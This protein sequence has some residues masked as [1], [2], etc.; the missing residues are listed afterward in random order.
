M[1]YSNHNNVEKAKPNREIGTESHGS[2]MKDRQVTM[3]LYNCVFIFLQ[4]LLFKRTDMNKRLYLPML[5]SVLLAGCGGG[6][7]STVETSVNS[8]PSIEDTTSAASLTAFE[9]PVL[10]ESTKQDYLDAI[11]SV[12]AIQQ[13]CGSEGIK[14]AVSPLVWNDK[15]YSIAAEHSIDLAAWNNGV[16]TEA[17]ASTRFS[18]E[19]SGTESDWTAQKQ[20][21]GRG[22]TTR[23]RVENSGYS[24]QAF[25]ENIA[26]GTTTDTAVAV[27]QQWLDSPPHCTNLMSS[28]YTEVGMA[29]V[30]DAN[31]FYIHYWTQN[32]GKPQ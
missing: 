12:R 23:E 14:P 7:T 6:G 31:S 25:G 26:A 17:E 27:V 21:L 20:E 22:S 4:S 13:D 18:H 24:W 15:L 2:F 5:I 8:I 28:N 29:M 16:V 9:A 19:G 1:I 10:S 11:N 32:F 3:T 30:E